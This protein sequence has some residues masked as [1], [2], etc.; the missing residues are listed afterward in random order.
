M[1]KTSGSSNWSKPETDHLLTILEEHE[2]F[3]PAEW[4]EVKVLFDAK[5]T[6]KNRGLLR[7][8]KILQ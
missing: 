3:R 4:E 6:K 5:Y 8:Q 2:P 1:V 7:L